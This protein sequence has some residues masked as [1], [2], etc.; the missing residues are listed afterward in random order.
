M[1][2]NQ[3]VKSGKKM[4]YLPGPGFVLP[5]GVTQIPFYS[6]SGCLVLNGKMTGLSILLGPLGGFGIF[7][8]LFFH[9]PL[10]LFCVLSL[11]RHTGR[12]KE[13]KD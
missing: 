7:F 9:F 11:Q 12:K 1:Y 4:V 3:P 6:F 5:V 8:P 13:K 10:D 2:A